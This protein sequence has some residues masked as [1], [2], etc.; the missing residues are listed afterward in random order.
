MG[1]RPHL[2][3]RGPRL[4]RRSGRSR[5][6]QPAPAA[7]S[8]EGGDLQVGRTYRAGVYFDCPE[9]G[10]LWRDDDEHA[11]VIDAVATSA[12][13]TFGLSATAGRWS[14]TP[15]GS[16]AGTAGSC[17]CNAEAGQSTP[18][19]GRGSTSSRSSGL[20]LSRN[21]DFYR[22]F[23][24]MLRHEGSEAGS[25]ITTAMVNPQLRA[26]I[27]HRPAPAGTPWS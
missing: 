3:A 11:A 7:P 17:S 23:Y 6:P 5:D 27:R 10:R 16:G 26:P 19:R 20:R 2:G 4:C 24:R 14:N 25:A 15:S 9:C 12:G 18:R 22:I 8:V 1:Q 21:F 13:A